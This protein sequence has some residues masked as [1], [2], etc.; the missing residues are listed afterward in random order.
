M[1]TRNFLSILLFFFLSICSNKLIAQNAGLYFDG[2]DD[3]VMSDISPI[4]GNTAKTVE[5]WIKTTA[6][7]NPSAGGVQK[8]IVE[9]GLMSTGT[10]FTFNLLNNNAIRIEVE[11]NGINGTTAVNDGL[12]HHVAGVYDPLATTKVA[13]YLDGV[14][15]ASGNLTVAVNTA[16]T[17]NIQI[18]RRCDG[19]HYF[20][21]TIDEVRV[22]NVA[23][24]ASQIANNRNVELCNST[25]NLVAYFPMNEGAPG[26][27]NTT[28]T[29]ISSYG[30][31]FGTGALNGFTLTGSTS[32]FVAGKT[33]A[34]G[35]SIKPISE[36]WQ[37]PMDVIRS[38]N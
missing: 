7:S 11:G 1:N 23:R 10:R 29:S 34:A 2:T 9:M 4:A 15:E 3:Y 25:A 28:N 22:W 26:A 36:E 30:N 38:S 16:S 24:T 12:W 5:A 19:I 35:L 31:T 27:T 32:N 37:K 17:G 13:L 8:V 21:G 14:L 18:G 6:N 33:L 20:N